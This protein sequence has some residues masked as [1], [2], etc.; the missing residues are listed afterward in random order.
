MYIVEKYVEYKMN[1]IG[2]VRS[3]SKGISENAQH[4]KRFGVLVSVYQCSQP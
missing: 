4:T 2:V 3:T 1:L